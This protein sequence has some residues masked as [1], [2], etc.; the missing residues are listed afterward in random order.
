MQK[1]WK[2]GKKGKKYKENVK[3]AIYKFDPS[4]Q[5]SPS[6]FLPP[7]YLFKYFYPGNFLR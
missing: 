5:P 6:L 4:F 2:N 7:L 1:A 3:D